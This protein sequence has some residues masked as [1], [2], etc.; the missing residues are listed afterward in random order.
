LPPLAKLCPENLR[1]S[2]LEMAAEYERH[3]KE[4]A[5]QLNAG[6]AKLKRAPERPLEPSPLEGDGGKRLA[7][8]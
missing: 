6:G 1:E 2:H 4:A 7:D 8:D 5:S 3:A